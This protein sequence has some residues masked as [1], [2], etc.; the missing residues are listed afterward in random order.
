MSCWTQVTVGAGR[1]INGN[2]FVIAGGRPGLKVSWQVTGIRRD[3][4]AEM[5]RV[6]VEEDKSAEDRGFYLHPEAFGKSVAQSLP[7]MRMNATGK[8]KLRSRQ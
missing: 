3:A 5:H 8:E 7:A 2:Q 1:E 4:Y 6:Q